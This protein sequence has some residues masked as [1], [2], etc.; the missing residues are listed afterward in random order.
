[1]RTVSAAFLQALTQSHT[2]ETSVTLTTPGG[3]T[4]PLL[5]ESGSISAKSGQIIRRTAPLVV[6]GD[7]DLYRQLSTPGALI[8]VQHGIDFGGGQTEL[9]PMIKGELASA[10][11]QIGD[12]LISCTVSDWG[13]RIEGTSYLTPVS[14]D[15]AAGRLA[16]VAAA[17][18]GGVPTTVQNLGTDTATIGTKQVW[19]SRSQQVLSL[20][21]DSGAEGFFQPDG[22]FLIRDLPQTTDDPV[23]VFRTG[24][25]GTIET[26]A[27][28]RP[29]D[30]LYNA[31]VV[32]PAS[33]DGSQPWTQITAQITDTG[34]PRHPNYIGLRPYVWQSPT[35]MTA[36]QA[37]TVAARLLN[38]V[39]GSTETIQLGAV[40]NPALEVG[41]VIR[42]TDVT[43]AGDGIVQALIDS[44][45]VDLVTGSMSLATRAA[46]ED[47]A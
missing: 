36:A 41:D 13:Q 30:K 9:V 6:E 22:V 39:Q 25:G 11:K 44:F 17:V 10:A 19:E 15:P 35:I 47:F 38:K 46:S 14:P 18:T 23:W 1:M 8:T 31:V 2:L 12:G 40:S 37:Q 32:R 7:S 27:R 29:L 20:L 33:L 42:A 45:T 34:N 3:S 26:F 24:D 21:Q 43:D 4:V 16:T 5:L 28:Q